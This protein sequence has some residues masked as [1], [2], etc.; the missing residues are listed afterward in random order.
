M[1]GKVESM[2]IG[3]A[4]SQESGTSMPGSCRVWVPTG[5]FALTL[6][7]TLLS[8]LYSAKYCWELQL[9]HLHKGSRGRACDGMARNCTVSMP[10][11]WVRHQLCC[12]YCLHQMLQSTQHAPCCATV[13]SQTSPTESAGYTRDLRLHPHLM[14]TLL[15]EVS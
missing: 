15:T 5:V 1:T 14:N 3:P 13:R 7:D 12:A 9:R 6:N 11:L 8:V 2:G 10:S 4:D